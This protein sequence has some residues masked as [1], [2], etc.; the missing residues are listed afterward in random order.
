MILKNS[1]RMASRTCQMSVSRSASNF[2]VFVSRRVRNPLSV[3]PTDSRR[4]CRGPRNSLTIRAISREM[5]PKGRCTGVAAPAGAAFAVGVPDV[6]A[7]GFGVVDAVAF[8]ADGGVDF[9]TGVGLGFGS[10]PEA[11]FGSA[12]GVGTDVSGAS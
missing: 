9:A 11:G 4:G 6:F 2:A 3:A 7:I 1:V 5:E 10:A 8:G 12:D